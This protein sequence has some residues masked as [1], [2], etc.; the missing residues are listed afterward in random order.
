[1]DSRREVDREERK[2]DGAITRAIMSLV[3][4]GVVVF[5]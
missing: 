4:R 1:M 2:E 3:T 5:L